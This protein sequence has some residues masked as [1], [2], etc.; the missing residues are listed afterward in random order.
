[1]SPFM[2]KMLTPTHAL[3]ERR[4]VRVARVHEHLRKSGRLRA[5]GWWGGAAAGSSHTPRWSSSM[6]ASCLRSSETSSAPASEQGAVAMSCQWC[7]KVYRD[8]VSLFCC[9]VYRDYVS[10]SKSS[11]ILFILHAALTQQSGIKCSPSVP[12]AGSS[13]Y[14]APTRLHLAVL[15][16]PFLHSFPP[17]LPRLPL[18]P[19]NT[20][21]HPFQLFLR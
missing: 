18:S 2:G 10:L 14:R 5:R 4:D 19:H 21:P 16:Y 20:P 3:I 13:T 7:C 11:S 12:H 1:M 17:R 6:R 9:N 8:Y 15:R